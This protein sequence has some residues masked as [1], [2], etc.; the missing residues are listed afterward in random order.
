MHRGLLTTALALVLFGAALPVSAAPPQPV[1]L[2]L[3]EIQMVGAQA[4]TKLAPSDA[5]LSLIKLGGAHDAEA[6]DFGEAPLATQLDA[7]ARVLT[8]DVAY[9]PKGGLFK[10]PAGASMA[11]EL[12][13]DDYVATMSQPGYKVIHVLDVD[14]KSSCMVF[15]ACLGQ[16]AAWSAKHPRHSALVIV[17]HVDANRTP[18]PGSTRPLPFDAAAAAA[19]DQEIGDVFPAAKLITPGQIKGEHA[20]LRDAVLA[21]GWPKLAEARGKVLFVLADSNAKRTA[22]YAAMPDHIGFVTADE[23]SPDAS[24]IAIDDP[25]KEGARITA[26]VKAGF[27]VMTLADDE[28]V[29]AR[30]NDTK[31]RDAAFASGAQIILTDFPVADKKIGPYEVSVKDRRHIQCDAVIADCTAW[32]ADASER[33]KFP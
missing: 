15:K 27:M 17:L 3:N 6:L 8:F 2:K 13:D 21:G 26:A 32:A 12:L 16:V 33:A 18:M 25:V 30:A 11:D 9:D 23:A 31:R 10:G 22:L 4:S 24:F 20:A 1:A 7:G 5:M 29:E 19:L 28:T 14:F